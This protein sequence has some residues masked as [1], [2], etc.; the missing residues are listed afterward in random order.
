MKEFVEKNKVGVSVDTDGENVAKI[1]EGMKVVLG[2]LDNY[3]NL[4]ADIVLW[5][6]Q[7]DVIERIVNKFV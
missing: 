3:N 1:V 6:T 7:N 5:D 4:R 2:N